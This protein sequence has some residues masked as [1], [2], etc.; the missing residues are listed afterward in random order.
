MSGSHRISRCGSVPIFFIENWYLLCCISFV[1]WVYEI[2]F[3]CFFPVLFQSLRL[4]SAYEVIRQVVKTVLY[5]SF[6]VLRAD[7]AN[8]E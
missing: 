4:L 5:S 3:S 8:V 7:Y 1:V 6:E 2:V